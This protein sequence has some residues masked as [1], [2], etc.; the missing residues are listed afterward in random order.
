MV[1][2]FFF[3]FCVTEEET[4]ETTFLVS[5]CTKLPGMYQLGRLEEIKP[6][7]LNSQLNPPSNKPQHK[8]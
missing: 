5:V 6:R 7:S 1:S 2:L 8:N 3:F 4:R